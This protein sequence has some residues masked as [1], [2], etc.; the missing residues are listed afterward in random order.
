MV[1]QMTDE[2]VSIKPD[3][4]EGLDPYR[5][6][7]PIM[8]RAWLRRA[9]LA[10]FSRKNTVTTWAED[11]TCDIA[12]PC[13]NT[14]FISASQ[15]HWCPRCHRGF[16]V[17]FDVREYP[18]F[19]HP[20]MARVTTNEQREARYAAERRKSDLEYHKKWMAEHMPPAPPSEPPK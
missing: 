4:E 15:P 20:G 19:L 9:I 18:R 16:Q 2:I 14:M 1:A 11:E 8:F 7:W 3:H 10:A 12:C 5:K 6:P 13:G 17:V